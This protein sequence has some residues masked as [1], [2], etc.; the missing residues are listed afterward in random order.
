LQG[1]IEGAAQGITS[2]G[3]NY[4]VEE[5]DVNPL[6]ANIG[7]SAISTAINSTLQSFAPTGEK[8]VFEHI[9]ETYQNNVLTFLGAGDPSDPN[10]AWQQAAYI[11][12]IQDFTTIIK[13]QGL[14]TALNTYATGF[15]NSTAVNA[16][17]S[18]GKTMGE[19]FKTKWDAGQTVEVG[20]KDEKTVK[21]IKVED[22][23]SILLFDDEGNII[24]L[25]EG[26]ELNFGEIGVDDQGKMALL[27]GY[28]DGSYVPGLGITMDI[29]DGYAT[30]AR[31]I[32]PTTGETLYWIRPTSDGGHI[33]FDSYGDFV[34]AGIEDL[35]NS[36]FNMTF[37]D[38]DVYEIREQI[39]FDNL[40]SENQAILESLGLKDVDSLGY[41]AF[42]LSS[43]EQLEKAFVS[44]E[45]NE[46]MGHFITLY[47]ELGAEVLEI[48][49][50]E[51][52]DLPLYAVVNKDMMRAL[53]IEYVGDRK[54]DLN[55]FQNYD[56]L[57]DVLFDKF[58]DQKA[59]EFLAAI[60]T[61][62]KDIDALN[63]IGASA[64]I[65]V[66]GTAQTYTEDGLLLEV[67]GYI[68]EHF[69]KT[70]NEFYF[71]NENKLIDVEFNI[72]NGINVEAEISKKLLHSFAKTTL[73]LT[74]KSRNDAGSYQFFSNVN[75]ETTSYQFYGT[76]EHGTYIGNAFDELSVAG[77]QLSSNETLLY[78]DEKVLSGEKVPVNSDETYGKLVYDILNNDKDVINQTECMLL[79]EKY[80]KFVNKA[81]ANVEGV[82]SEDITQ[83]AEAQ[84]N[85]LSNIVSTG[86]FE[87]TKISKD[88]VYNIYEKLVLAESVQG[89]NISNE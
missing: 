77:R 88:T 9:Y 44:I 58:D 63:C 46:A 4:L 8:D 80:L 66:G 78:V 76:N 74:E 27:K 2:V 81:F 43:E 87:L 86:S 70:D 3:L 67:S 20:L 60:N 84:V 42:E 75:I 15:F 62:S 13:E 22:T 54:I 71:D 49:I 52:M 53:T 7:F 72:K 18:T 24:G 68:G 17:M 38:K 5:M 34:D 83:I 26:E 57:R 14:E 56:Q 61:F 39:I 89:V 33:T 45:P 65:L 16:I 21:G 82:T 11:A 51:S 28:I 30:N 10:Y 29:E 36:N 73:S 69:V 12:Q 25:K 85:R 47:P 6:L 35:K 40:S 59:T 1:A 64:N 55:G 32:N 31:I 50:E 41:F 23:E 79:Q 48:F 37:K 19:Y